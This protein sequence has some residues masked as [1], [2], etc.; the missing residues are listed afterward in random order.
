LQSRKSKYLIFFLAF[1]VLGYLRERFFVHLNIIMTG[2]YRGT[3]EYAKLHLEIPTLMLPFSKLS[4]E[5]L[6]FSKYLYTLIWVSL[7]FFLSHLSLRHLSSSKKIL[8][9]L[10]YSYL[11]LLILAGISMAYGYF[12]NYR[13]KDDEYTFSRW[14]MGIAQSPLICLFMLAAEKL[15]KKSYQTKNK[16]I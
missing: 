13:L 10:T 2:I 6:Y 11:I 5:V 16:E 7:F 14:L 9:F 12:I 1:G 3:D 4:Y 15:L 8:K